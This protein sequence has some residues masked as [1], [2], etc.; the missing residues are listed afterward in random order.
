MKTS[1]R[2]TL[3]TLL[4]GSATALSGPALAQQQTE[5]NGAIILPKG[6]AQGGADVQG[7]AATQSTE[8]QGTTDGSAA[9]N[10]T[11]ETPD[12]GA[13]TPDASG[14][15]AASTDT[16]TQAP[17][18]EGST[19]KQ[20][21][22]QSKDA[23]GKTGT[24]SGSTAESDKSGSADAATD[25][26]PSDTSNKSSTESRGETNTNTSSSS[27]TTVNVTTE[28][29]TEIH[30]VIVKEDVKPVHVD[31]EVNV[32]VVVPRTVELRPLPPRIIK[33]VPAYRHY[34]YI[35]LADGRILIIEPASLKI[36][37]VVTA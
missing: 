1:M 18:T 8:K 30:N 20:G 24:D 16:Q 3:A 37:F 13:A 35:L 21:A 33:L 25:S 34:K 32:G 14:S 29:R 9:G 23:T 17:S 4:L 12:G 2:K 10:A 27:E 11:A 22:S 5:Q 7:G 36:V 31:F 28:Q 26:K 6:K 15:G 19:D